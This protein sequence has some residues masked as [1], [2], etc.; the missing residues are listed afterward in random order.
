MESYTEVFTWGGDHFGQLGLGSK[1]SGKTYPS[2]RFCSFNILIKEISC[3]EEHSAFISSSNH[4]YSMGSNSEGRLG[5]G[6]KS[7]RSSSSPCLVESLSN[8]KAIRVS[9]GWGHS[10]VI[11]DEGL[12]F[13]WGVGEFGALGSGSSENSWTPSKVHLPR[14]LR[15]VDINCGSRHSGLVVDE[16]RSKTL[17]M[18]GSGE[19]GQLGTGK[20]EKEF[21]FVQVSLS[22]DIHSVA[23]G[24]FHSLVLTTSGKVFAMGGNSFGQ[25]GIGTKKSCSRPERVNIEGSAVKVACGSHS[26]AINDRGVLFLWGTGVFGEFLTPTRVPVGVCKDVSVGGN[27]GIALDISGELHA[28]GANSNGELGVGDYEPRA[29]P[30]VVTQL[31]GKNVKRLSCGGNYV[32][33]LGNDVGERNLFTSQPESFKGTRRDDSAKR[34]EDLRSAKRE[35]SLKRTEAQK[36]LDGEKNRN[37]RLR[38]SEARI[39]ENDRVT[40]VKQRDESRLEVR[41]VEKNSNFYGRAS[42]EPEDLRKSGKDLVLK[43]EN[44]ISRENDFQGSFSLKSALE[45]SQRQASLLQQELKNYKDEVQ[46]LKKI[47]EDVK[48][49]QSIETSQKM[50]DLNQSLNHKHMIEMQDLKLS[51]EQELIRRRQVEKNLDV[52]SKHISNLEEALQK[53]NFENSELKKQ[54]LEVTRNAE[55]FKLT[56]QQEMDKNQ[57]ENVELRRKIDAILN[58]KERNEINFNRENSEMRKKFEVLMMEKERTEDSLTKEIFEARRKNEEILTEKMQNENNSAKENHDLR[59]RLELLNDDKS[60][61]E[62][63]LSYE[64]SELRQKLENTLLDKSRNES[65]LSYE[66]SE[67]R[68]KLEN[69]LLDKDRL[70]S[71]YKSEISVLAS[72]LSDLQVLIT[73]LTSENSHINSLFSQETNKSHQEISEYRLKLTQTI[74][75]KDSLISSLQSELLSLKSELSSTRSSLELANSEISSLSSRLSEK[76]LESSSQAE[77]LADLVSK[78]DYSMRLLEDLK[79]QNQKLQQDS[80]E[81]NLVIERLKGQISQWEVEYKALLNDNRI[82][83]ESVTELEMKNRQLFENLEKELAQRAKEYKDRTISILNTGRSVSPFLRSHLRE[84]SDEMNVSASKMET[85]NSP[86][87][88]RN[89]KYL[90]IAQAFR[91]TPTKEDVRNRIASL[92]RNREKIEEQLCSIEDNV[93]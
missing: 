59:R 25:L 39:R 36:R 67:L 61:N 91:E 64:I 32:I 65:S 16:G 74:H 77:A 29:S 37:E 24:V 50:E 93:I 76:T 75:D 26:A 86:N 52:S 22:E 45:D 3:G 1:H 68:Q 38:D 28:W 2:P 21:K 88:A 30:A 66:I 31:K 8:Y 9:C 83:K 85:E 81:L 72:Q 84:R 5:I 14:H 42:R 55:G 7:L 17:W 27:F 11:T 10:A 92:M 87:F 70:E 40:P 78:N 34:T 46:R 53:Y 12:L 54:L 58:E 15:P 80:S 4:V 23:C 62:S 35:E 57:R 48:I 71:S 51:Q 44:R 60:R 41:T 73:N 13:T 6:D 33:G 47:M 20:R 18:T 82:L 19:A 79:F 63:S 49:S 89:S 90:T 69:T 43:N 56:A